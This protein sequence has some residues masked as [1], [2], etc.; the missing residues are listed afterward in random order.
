MAYKSTKFLTNYPTKSN[1]FRNFPEQR[2]FGSLRSNNKVA[3][4]INSRRDH[5]GHDEYG[6]NAHVKEFLILLISG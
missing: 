5:F 1:K 3:E 4:M 2:L 6:G